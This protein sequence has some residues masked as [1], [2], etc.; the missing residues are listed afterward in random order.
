MRN[1]KR[2]EITTDNEDDDDEDAKNNNVANALIMIAIVTLILTTI[3]TDNDRWLDYSF[4]PVTLGE[5]NYGIIMEE[6]PRMPILIGMCSGSWGIQI[7]NM[8]KT[9]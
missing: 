6:P 3:H 1:I 4:S 8:T 5:Y 2:L 7:R 9:N